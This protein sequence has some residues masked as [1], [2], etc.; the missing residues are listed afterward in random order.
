MVKF[1]HLDNHLLYANEHTEQSTIDERQ[2]FVFFAENLRELRTHCGLSLT[3]LA[4]LLDIPNQTLSSY[5][6]KTHVPSV[7]QAVK[8]AAYFGLYVEDFILCG[9]DEYPYDIIELYEKRKK[10]LQ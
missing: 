1:F 8:I 2:A 6:N 7:I 10:S 3:E 5:E 9:I 4:G